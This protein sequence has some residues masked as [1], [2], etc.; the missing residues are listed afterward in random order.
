LLD[1][2][3]AEH[4]RA[5]RGG[6]PRDPW[7][8]ILW[9][10][11][12]YLT[13]DAHRDAALAKLRAATRLDADVL[14]RVPDDVLLPICGL[15]RMAALCVGKLRECAR[16]FDDV[17]DPR[18][19]VRLPLAEARKALREFPGVGAPGADRLILFAGALPLVALESNGLRTLLRLGFGQDAGS[20]SAKLKSAIAA[21]A[22]EV[23][24][25]CDARIEW[26]TL[27]RRHGQETCRATPN[28]AVC[29]V[30]KGCPSRR[31]A[32]GGRR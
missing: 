30:A 23:A 15:G 8:A 21:V 13:D 26:F 2:L 25:T 16:C 17:G 14:A 18:G 10:N 3:R 11:V 20:Y 12:V 22:G 29:A 19:L 28:C 6:P 24:E 32:G 1:A 5:M 4:G 9:E 7:H 27:L 31:V